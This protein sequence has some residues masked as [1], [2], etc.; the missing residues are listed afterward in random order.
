[1]LAKGQGHV[2]CLAP[3]QPLSHSRSRQLHFFFSLAT[4][5]RIFKKWRRFSK[6]LLEHWHP[7]PF[8]KISIPHKESRFDYWPVKQSVIVR[9]MIKHIDC[10]MLMA[11]VIFPL[12]NLRKLLSSF[13][14]R[15]KYS[16]FYSVYFVQKT[17]KQNSFRQILTTVGESPGDLNM[18][19]DG[20]STDTITDYSAVIQWLGFLIKHGTFFKR[21]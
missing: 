18:I 20:M 3:R 19:F 10:L 5:K 1:M 11:M 9:Q 14:Y 4:Q 8:S 13:M 17:N 7:E 21:L 16:L 6:E 12:K 15:I 2:G